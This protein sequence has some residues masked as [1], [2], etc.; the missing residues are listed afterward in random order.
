METQGRKLSQILA[1]DEVSKDVLTALLV[2]TVPMGAFRS[3]A[4]LKTIELPDSVVSIEAYAFSDCTALAAI[5]LPAGVT[6]IGDEAFCR[7][8]ALKVQTWTTNPGS[9]HDTTMMM[10]PGPR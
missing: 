10:I 7:C 4:A 3:C 9:F 1:D 5:E 2:H 6:S 8:T